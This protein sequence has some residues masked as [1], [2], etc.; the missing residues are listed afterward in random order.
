MK[1]SYILILSALLLASC[2]S[3]V[4]FT[5]ESGANKTYSKKTGEKP[6]SG[7]KIRGYASYYSEEF[8]GRLTASG[9]VFDMNAMTAA[10][11]TF[12]F[13]T[14]LKVTNL[15]NNRSVIVYINDRGPFVEGRIIDLS[16][17]AAKKLGMIAD[18]VVEVEI[19][20]IE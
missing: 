9:E 18:G 1:C 20:V 5:S 13:G 8:N 6:A 3:A 10:H 12:A 2:S 7:T 11:K 15:K 14:K 4:R 19:E 17:G 16:L